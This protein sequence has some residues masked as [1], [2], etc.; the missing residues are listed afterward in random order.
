M[1]NPL[2]VRRS[3]FLKDGQK[4]GTEVYGSRTDQH[5]HTRARARACAGSTRRRDALTFAHGFCSVGTVGIT[6]EVLADFNACLDFGLQEVYLFR[7]VRP[8]G[9]A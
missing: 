5:T 3:E 9:K 1:K 6:L 8:S 4:L 2:R 7:K